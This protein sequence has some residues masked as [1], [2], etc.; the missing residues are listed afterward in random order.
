MQKLKGVQPKMEKIAMQECSLRYHVIDIDL[1]FF[2]FL[3]T[4][5]ISPGSECTTIVHPWQWFLLILTD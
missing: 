2:F 3:S 4:N 5:F 1:F